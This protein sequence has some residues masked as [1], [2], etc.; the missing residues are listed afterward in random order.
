MW[1]KQWYITDLHTKCWY[2][3]VY[4]EI[5]YCEWKFDSTM[6][7][8]MYMC[9]Y[10]CFLY[11]FWL[12]WTFRISY[13]HVAFSVREKLNHNVQLKLQEKSFLI[14]LCNDFF[15][16]VLHHDRMEWLV[17]I[18]AYLTKVCHVANKSW[19]CATLCIHLDILFFW[20]TQAIP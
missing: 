7:G 13:L 1:D 5:Y 15:C 10:M 16:L 6:G 19:L 17:I 2:I 8:Y 4:I 14:E 12:L 20:T 3:Q 9:A 11:G 18:L